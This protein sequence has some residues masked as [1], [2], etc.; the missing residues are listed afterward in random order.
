MKKQIKFTSDL[1]YTTTYKELKDHP[2]IIRSWHENKG[3]LTFYLT[4]FEGFTAQVTT[5][6]YFSISYPEERH[7][8]NALKQ[9][10][11]LLKRADGTQ[12]R[13]TFDGL[14]E[15]VDA[16]YKQINNLKIRLDVFIDRMQ[17]LLPF[18]NWDEVRSRWKNLLNQLEGEIVNVGINPIKEKAFEV[19]S[20]KLLGNDFFNKKDKHD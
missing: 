3:R 7:Y 9:I 20:K 16:M 15:E 2:V 19:L 14:S 18:Y 12:A 10:Q 6:G 13:I 17:P 1:D 11:P 4:K 8:H 5:G